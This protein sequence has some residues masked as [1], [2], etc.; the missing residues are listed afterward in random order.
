MAEE[1]PEYIKAQLVTLDREQVFLL[2][3]TFCG[4]VEKT[5][6]AVKVSPVTILAVADEEKWNEQLRAIIELK[7]SNRPGDLERAINRALNFA[8]AHRFRMFLERVIQKVCGMSGEEFEAYLFE[9]HN[10][11]DGS[12]YRSLTTRALADLASALEK[13]QS[14][15]YH[16]LN[17]TAQERVKRKDVEGGDGVAA[18][19][20]HSRIAA[21]MSKVRGSTTP[22]AQLFDAQLEI[23]EG[24]TLRAV[25]VAEKVTSN[26]NDNDDH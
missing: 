25:T 8:Q 15:T 17:D 3:A 21:A 16:A 1:L 23:A 19:D 22:R 26:P 18:G 20:M 11:K 4:D 2:Y 14:M 12:T 7:K 10:A 24:E 9:K 5:A 6:H 13:A